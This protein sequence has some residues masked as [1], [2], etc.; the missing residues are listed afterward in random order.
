MERYETDSTR[1]A[2][3]LHRLGALTW[4]AID[5]TNG[6]AHLYAALNLCQ[7]HGDDRRRALV[8]MELGQAKSSKTF[9][10]HVN[11]SEALAH[12]Q[13]AEPLIARKDVR[14]L[15]K[16]YRCQTAVNIEA[17][18]IDE[19]LAA[20]ERALQMYEELGDEFSWSV[21]AAHR[22]RY[23]MVRGRLAEATSLLERIL[24]VALAIPD[25]EASSDALWA[26]GLY[27]MFML[28]A[29]EA[30][31]LFMLG[32]ER[33]GVSTLQ[34]QRI[35][36]FVA[37]LDYVGGD[38]ARARERHP[39]TS[40]QAQIALRDGDW[41][42]M[43]TLLQKHL[44]WAQARGIKWVIFDTLSVLFRM[45][46]LTGDYD[47]A[48]ALQPRVLESYRSSE[49][50]CEMRA[51]PTATLLALEFGRTDEASTHLEYCRRIV[52][53]GE[54]WQGCMGSVRRAE[55][56]FAAAENRIADSTRFFEESIKIF[57]NFGSVWDAAD[58]LH[59]WGRALLKAGK[60]A[61]A[62]E[63]LDGAIEV[64]RRHGAGQRWIERVEADRRRVLDTAT[65]AGESQAEAC[66][67][68]QASCSFYQEGEYW[69]VAFG[70]KTARLKD[71]KG[72]HY[73]ADLLRHPGVELPAIDLAGSNSHSNRIQTAVAANGGDFGTIHI[74]LGDAGPH[75]D[76]KAKADYA[77]RIR[78]LDAELDEAQRF[79]DPGKSGL[80]RREI[81]ALTAQLK[82]ATGLRGD[83]RVASHVERA[84][85]TVSQRI[86]F[87]IRQIR[88][89]NPALAD[90]LGQNIRT[91]YNCAYLP[92]EKIEW[93]L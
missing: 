22:T 62:L 84:R 66:A 93:Q 89:L 52:R 3:L 70:E 51:R 59:L 58:T 68:S 57:Q 31:R 78:E 79:N 83:R 50:F 33:P 91:G 10:Q 5:Y 37:L 76:A 61:S 74:D 77:R 6:I 15:A 13:A 2:D 40:F 11:I 86:R 88:K 38:L 32:V 75:L 80:I 4:E 19:G 53:Q 8:H 41:D 42:S 44:E 73:L 28:A 14:S 26:A 60:S 48:A 18:M 55:A 23:L 39:N 47:G 82:A 12:Y 90:H 64:Y 45:L 43:R 36:E 85:S 46:Y 71:A 63:K 30:R 72:F 65:R 29:P 25:P 16:L 67:T 81:E 34:R 56:A 24:Q 17:L 27:Y 1:R 87:A 9:G 69:V 35:L 49:Q 20:S 21:T 7:Q 54:D 92:K